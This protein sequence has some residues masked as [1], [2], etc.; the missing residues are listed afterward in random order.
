MKKE[1]YWKMVNITAFIMR[2]IKI[3]R[4]KE[5]ADELILMAKEVEEAENFWIRKA[6]KDIN[7]NKGFML[8]RD[9]EGILRCDSRI[10]NYMLILL[11]REHH[12]TRLIIEAS[13]KRVLH[14][15]V[16]ATM[17]CVR[18]RFWGAAAS[19]NRQEKNKRV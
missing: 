11:P 1:A 15:G 13:H 18:E 4:N 19:I 8:R 17:A 2:F 3:C 12:L 14:D 9:D 10:P 5:R 7:G 6:Q 16:A